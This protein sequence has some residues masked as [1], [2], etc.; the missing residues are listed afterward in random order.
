MEFGREWRRWGLVEEGRERYTIG[1][2]R[3]ATRWKDKVRE[4]LGRKDGDRRMQLMTGGSGTAV[5]SRE[6]WTPF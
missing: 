4:D 2:R 5:S 6:T 3:L 1:G